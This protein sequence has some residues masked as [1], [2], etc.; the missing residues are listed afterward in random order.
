[1]KYICT[2]NAGVALTKWLCMEGAR[3][4]IHHKTLSR[5][6]R[7]YLTTITWCTCVESTK[8]KFFTMAIDAYSK[9]YIEI[10]KFGSNG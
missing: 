7:C 3:D 5:N 9:I 6:I 10:A 4:E 1:M 8:E 2:R